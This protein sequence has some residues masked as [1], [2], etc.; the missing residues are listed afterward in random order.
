MPHIT[1]FD[2]FASK[3]VVHPKFQPEGDGFMKLGDIKGELRSDQFGAVRGPLS[4]V[5]QDGQAFIKGPEGQLLG[6]ISGEGVFKPQEI[7]QKG[8][9][10]ADD[11]HFTNGADAVGLAVRG[12][13]SFVQ[14]DGQ[15]FIKGPEGQLLGPISGEGVFKP[16]EVDQK[17]SFIAGDNHF[18]NGADAVGLA[19]RGPLSDAQPEVD[20]VTGQQRTAIVHPQYQKEAKGIVHP[21]YQPE[22]GNAIVHLEDDA[23][24]NGG[25]RVGL[26]VGPV[27]QGGEIWTNGGASTLNPDALMQQI[28]GTDQSV[29]SELDQGFVAAPVNELRSDNRFVIEPMEAMSSFGASP[30]LEKQ[31][32]WNVISESSTPVSQADVMPSIAIV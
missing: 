7:D 8:S 14:Q 5:Q 30:V 10:I 19:V 27:N 20:G 18:T 2:G 23:L 29:F 12:P 28:N 32:N 15:T 17:G 13:L 4:F 11:N 24:I 9:F 22:A 26:D 6:P 31:S 25:Q 16:Q 1:T 3:A 21:Q